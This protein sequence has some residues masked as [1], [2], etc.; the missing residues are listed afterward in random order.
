MDSAGSCY[1]VKRR[2]A[3]GRGAVNI[4]LPICSVIGL[5]SSSGVQSTL[6]E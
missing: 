5:A 4:A 2:Q 6:I 3:D 1:G